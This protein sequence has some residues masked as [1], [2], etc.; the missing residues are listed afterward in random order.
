L[1]DSIPRPLS[2]RERGR[3]GAARRWADH[4]GP[5]RIDDLT[6]EQRRL[7]LALIDAARAEG[8]K[9]ADPDGHS[10]SAQEVQRVSAERPISG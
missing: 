9:K 4:P 8:T 1:Q 5:V 3:L 7:V 10:G 6:P 2:H